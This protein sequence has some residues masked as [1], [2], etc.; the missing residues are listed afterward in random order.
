MQWARHC[1]NCSYIGYPPVTPAIMVLVHD[2]ERM[3][4]ARNVG[5]K[6]LYSVIAGFVEPGET[7]EDCVRREVAE[8][9]GL[10]VTDITYVGSQPWPFPH[11]L[12]L[13]FTA[14]YAG[15]HL[16]PDPHEIAD[17]GWF[18]PH[19]LPAELPG[20]TSLAWRLISGHMQQ[21][22]IYQERKVELSVR[23]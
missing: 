1:T 16:C 6:Q 14:R 4:L 10:S 17:A 7:L 18:S 11:Q 21:M 5:W 19:T 9:V 22:G 8:E 20:V 13:G 23:A 3:L 15:G 2:G 12:M